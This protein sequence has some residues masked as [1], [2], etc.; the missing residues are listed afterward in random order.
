MLI[1]KI[2]S[3]GLEDRFVSLVEG[4]HTVGSSIDSDIV[5]LDGGIDPQHFSVVVSP[6]GVAVEMSADSSGNLQRS[7]VESVEPVDPGSSFQWAWGDT[8][9]LGG[10]R[11]QMQGDVLRNP[12]FAAP[13]PDSDGKT[14]RPFRIKLVGSAAA[15]L[16]AAIL[17]LT[18]VG[19]VETG[20]AQAAPEA[21]EAEAPAIEMADNNLPDKPDRQ[22]VL[23]GLAAR[24]ITVAGFAPLGEGWTGTVRVATQSERMRVDASLGALAP[25][26]TPRFFVDDRLAAA[27]ELVIRS[28]A[29]K[30]V[31]E[32]V[33]NGE[34]MVSGIAADAPKAEMLRDN[35][36]ADVPGLQSVSFDN[37]RQESL[38]MVGDKIAGTWAGKFPYVLLE[39]GKTVRPGEEISKDALLIQ[40][41]Q[42]AI[43]VEIGES[44]HE[45]KLQ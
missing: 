27:A 15:G 44:R 37:G 10:T 32:S 39:D 1:V 31:I 34:I 19:A 23:A 6:E 8:L 38:D 7:Q 12:A 22:E 45:V 21:V 14:P 33:A 18:Q 36:M 28:I 11:I 2:I 13:A 35:L 43:I 3:D 20:E 5:L 9:I 4:V 41:H 29:P 25:Y 40:V 16:F 17:I 30:A 42:Q 24:G 26:F